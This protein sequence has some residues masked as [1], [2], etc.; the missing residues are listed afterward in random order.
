MYEHRHNL[1][2]G[3]TKRY[4]V[5]ILVYY[6]VHEDAYIAIEREKQLKWWRRKW[7]LE[8]IEKHNPN[9]ID[10]VQP[11]GTILPLPIE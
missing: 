2:E 11:D 8:L 5:H 9:W 3:F 7:K 6:E 4:N 1:T 10:L